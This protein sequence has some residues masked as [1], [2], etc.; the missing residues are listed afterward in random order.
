[1]KLPY[2]IDS[3]LKKKFSQIYSEL[4]ISIHDKDG[5]IIRTNKQVCDSY[6]EN[7]LAG[8]YAMFANLGSGG[9][10][11]GFTAPHTSANSIFSI[12]NVENTMSAANFAATAPATNAVNGLVLGTGSVAPTPSSRALTSPITHG[13]GPGQLVY[14]AGQCLAGTTILG[15]VSSFVLLRSFTNSSA[16]TITVREVALYSSLTATHFMLLMDLLSPAQDVLSLQT[17]TIQLTTQLT[18]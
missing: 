4:V 16:S 12:I 14:Q 15:N 13:S 1:M 7:F 9:I 5:K 11:Y 3:K 18:T 17:I 10:G 6:T 2:F 8:I